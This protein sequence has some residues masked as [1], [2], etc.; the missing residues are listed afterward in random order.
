MSGVAEPIIDLD[1]LR[2]WIGRQEMVRDRLPPFPAAALAATLDRDDAF[3][4]GDLL[5]PLWHWVYFLERHKTSELAPNGH[6]RHGGFLPPM[7]LP[8][9]MFA[10]ARLRFE[11][12]LRLET[13]ATRIATITGIT[14]K[15]GASGPL[16]FMGLR[17]E[18]RTHAGTALVE[19]QDIV[20]RTAPTGEERPALA[21]RAEKAPVWL[22]EVEANEVRLFRYSPLIFNAHRI[23]WDRPYATGHEGY[24]GLVVH[25]Q[26]IATWLAELVRRHSERPIRSFRFR[27]LRALLEHSRCRL[28][29]LPG[30]EGVKLWAEDAQGAM[31]MEAFA[32][33]G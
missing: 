30:P 23:D 7:P 8:R 17:N 15:Q 24:P 25:G 21:R 29:G 22:H 28:C 1:A 5:P 31:V 3:E 32:E 6:V 18:I 13:E 9:R 11:R 12:A 19:D 26:L 4:S 14:L 27:S 2:P 10:G 16:L 33:L 20:Y